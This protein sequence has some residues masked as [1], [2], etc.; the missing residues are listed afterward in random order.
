MLSATTTSP[1]NVVITS[2]MHRYI[3][4]LGYSRRRRILLF[5]CVLYLLLSSTSINIPL[6]SQHATSPRIY[7]NTTL[8]S[9]CHPDT[10]KMKIPSVAF[11]NLGII[12]IFSSYVIYASM[13]SYEPLLTPYISFIVAEGYPHS[14]KSKT[15]LSLYR[16]NVVIVSL[17]ST[18]RRRIS[19]SSKSLLM[20]SLLFLP[21]YSTFSPHLSVR[22]VSLVKY[23]AIAGARYQQKQILS[24]LMIGYGIYWDNQ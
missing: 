15:P 13:P 3:A 23:D 5:R 12:P 19:K 20:V 17:A 18:A 7:P 21:L 22:R 16:S 1:K 6:N 2:S 14:Q 4:D 10:I 9:L 8:P 11:K 24:E